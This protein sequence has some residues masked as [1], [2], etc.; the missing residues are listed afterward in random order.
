MTKPSGAPQDLP[1]IVSVFSL[2]VCFA[3][4]SD[5]DHSFIHHSFMLFPEVR[6]DLILS[7]TLQIKRLSLEMIQNFAASLVHPCVGCDKL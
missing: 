1:S 4:A 2:L 7:Q 3:K 5:S 6:V